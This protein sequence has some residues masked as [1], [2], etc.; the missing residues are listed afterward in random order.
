M[1]SRRPFTLTE[2]ALALLIILATG[3]LVLTACL[4]RVTHRIVDGATRSRASSLAS[5]TAEELLTVPYADL[6][7][8]THDDPANP[9]DGVYYIRWV[10]EDEQPHRHCK[11]VTVKVARRTASALPEAQVVVVAP[12]SG[13]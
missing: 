3:V 11:R 4:P 5:E 9:H 13:G 8:G 2:L 6:V 10:I 12:G 7:A 1:P